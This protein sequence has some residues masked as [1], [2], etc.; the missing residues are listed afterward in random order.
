MRRLH[1][2]IELNSMDN[3][4]FQYQ[5]W[6]YMDGSAYFNIYTGY[7]SIKKPAKR[8]DFFKDFFYGIYKKEP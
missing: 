2:T 8:N 3:T 1:Y 7:E 5:F 6:I 4:I